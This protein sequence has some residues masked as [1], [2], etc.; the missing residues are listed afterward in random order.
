MIKDSLKILL[1][2]FLMTFPITGAIILAAFSEAR[3]R[4]RNR[5]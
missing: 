1:G 4:R 5:R 3:D 2:F